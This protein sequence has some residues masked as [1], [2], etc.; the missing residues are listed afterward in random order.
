[1]RKKILW[2]WSLWKNFS[3]KKLR[4][5]KLKLFTIDQNLLLR[6][7]CPPTGPKMLLLMKV[8]QVSPWSIFLIKPPLPGFFFIFFFLSLKAAI[9]SCFI[10]CRKL[11]FLLHNF[12]TE[13]LMFLLL[14]LLSLSNIGKSYHCCST[15]SPVLA[16]IFP[17][18]FWNSSANLHEK[19]DS[20]CSAWDCIRLEVR[21]GR[22]SSTL[23]RQHLIN[24]NLSKP[25]L[26]T[27]NRTRG[28]TVSAY[29]Y[30][31]PKPDK[32]RQ[33]WSFTIL[34]LSYYTTEEASGNKASVKDGDTKSCMDHI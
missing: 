13:H 4:E 20:F 10:I 23:F 11:S 24:K 30:H 21:K 2:L 1:M 19:V 27:V 29:I 9:A 14:Y 32:N 5:K 28:K 15:Q 18:L 22:S 12:I 25:F 3:K 31:S 26:P 33:L 34:L 6:L 7:F 8:S 16:S 17:M